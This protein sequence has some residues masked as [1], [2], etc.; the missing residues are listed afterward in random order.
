MEFLFAVKKAED[1][2][3]QTL[4]VEGVLISYVSVNS[5]L[6]S[7]TNALFQISYCCKMK[8]K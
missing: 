4:R 7:I 1:L 8:E 5:L 2:E 6:I 3:A